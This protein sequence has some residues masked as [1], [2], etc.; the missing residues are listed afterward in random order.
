[1]AHHR[2]TRAEISL[3]A[4]KQ[5][6]QNLKTILGSTTGIMAVIKADAY[7]HGALPCARA[8]VES[9]IDYLGAGVIEEGIELRKNGIENPILILGSIF[10]DEAADLVHH[11]LSTILC[12][13]HLAETLSREAKKQGKLVNIHIKVDTGMNRLGVLPENLLSLTDKICN[14]PNLKIEALSTHF[15][16][17]DDE[18]LSITNNQIELFQKALAQI[19]KKGVVPPLTHLANTS[20]LFRFPESH[21]KMVRPG[22]ILYGAL[23][24]PILNPVVQDVCK[25]KNLESF[26]GVMQWKSKIILLKPVKKGQALSY[27]GKYSTEKDSIIAT[28]PIGYADGLPRR[29]SNKMDVLVKGRRA[30][31]V[32]AICMDMTLID[33]T[34]IPDVQMGDE[35]VIFGKQ[36]NEVIQVEELAQKANTIPYELLCNVG[37]R[38]PRTYLS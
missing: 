19:K 16:S 23:P 37:K 21:S 13:S 28:L 30:P 4:F 24:S 20:A 22:L 8:A 25:K 38:V 12:T 31:Q 27:S 11:N 7:G 35:V 36:G 32:G 10:P 2:A 15:S 29:L 6:L 3:K 34:D 17:A 18:D 1:M 9:G 14:L 5:N 26:E 33:V